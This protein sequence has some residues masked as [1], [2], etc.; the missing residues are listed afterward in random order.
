MFKALATPLAYF[1]AVA[2]LGSVRAAAEILRIAPS[3]LSRQI[4]RM[5][6]LAGLALF[7][8]LPRGVNLTPA[9][10]ILFSYVQ[11]WEKDFSGLNDDLRSL[12]GLRAGTLRLATVEIATYSV[13]PRAIRALRDVMPGITVNTNVGVTDGVLRDVAEGKAEVG[14]VINMPKAAGVRS[15]WGVRTAVGAVV[16]PDHPLAQQQEARIADCLA[17]PI[18]MPDET[19][20][21]RSAIRRALERTRRGV[22]IA[23]T[24]NRIASI[25][26]LAKAGVGV[27]FL[28]ELDVSSEIEAG[29]FSFIKLKDRDIEAPYIS[30]VVSK[31][32]KLSPA[33]AKFLDLLKRELTPARDTSP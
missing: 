33:A 32:D 1:A 21:V 3:A 14:V 22:R 26:G 16:L 17:Y 28:V 9:G 29:E 20:M 24:C 11:R 15:A 2:R 12:A 5:E 31:H 23:G 19:L 10:E 30:L 8:R 13:V 25:K 4:R 18:I 27:A 7:E 6:D